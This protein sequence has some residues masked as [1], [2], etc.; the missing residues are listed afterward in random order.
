MKEKNNDRK[1][2]MREEKDNKFEI[3]LS[4][5]KNNKKSQQPLTRDHKQ[6]KPKIR[7]NRD[8]ESIS[9]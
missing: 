8:P 7:N 3:L 6:K 9:Q 5:T 4:E 2:E 1:T